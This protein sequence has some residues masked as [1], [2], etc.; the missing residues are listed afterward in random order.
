MFWFSKTHKAYTEFAHIHMLRPQ[1][2]TL[3]GVSSPA[4]IPAWSPC[5]ERYIRRQ[6]A[7][8]HR[9]LH[10]LESPEHIGIPLAVEEADSKYFPISNSAQE[11]RDKLV[12]ACL[13]KGVT[14]RYSFLGV[15]HIYKAQQ[16]HL[17]SAC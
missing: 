4:C 13:K 2:F 3:S 15:P 12:R 9:C 10:R 8:L 6:T 7:T 17:L 11:V 1:H 14:F 5:A 16:Q